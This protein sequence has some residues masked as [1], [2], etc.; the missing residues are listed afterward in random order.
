MDYKE[1]LKKGRERLPKSALHHERFEIPKIK[2]HIEGNKTVLTNFNEI[3]SAFGRES[4]HF[5][6]FLLKGLATPGDLKGNRLIL[7]RKLSSTQIN[8]KIESYAKEFVLCKE[9]KK[10]DTRIVKKDNVFF[11]Q[12]LACGARHPIRN[13]I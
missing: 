8:E 13:K 2:G 4:D 5:L 1:L 11:L 10:P 7:G 6:K 12:C 3:V 9:C